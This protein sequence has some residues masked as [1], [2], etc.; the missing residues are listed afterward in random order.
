MTTEELLR[1]S[2]TLRSL[3]QTSESRGMRFYLN[4]PAEV[5]PEFL[6]DFRP[7]AIARGPEG[8]MII[9]LTYPGR[10]DAKAPLDEIS[11]LVA[12]QK[13]WEF[14]AIYINPL[15]DPYPTIA[16]PTRR[17]LEG[18]FAEIE[19]LLKAGHPSQAFV[20][21]WGALESLA[22]LTSS[23]SED[24]PRKGFSPAQAIQM[25]AQDGY[26][27]DEP[28]KRLRRMLTLRDAVVH[29]D[30]SVDV[31]KDEVEWLLATLRAITAEFETFAVL[32]PIV[33][34]KRPRRR[35]SSG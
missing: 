2:P 6:G 24:K 12:A 25:L 32:E 11:K 17:Q 22:R 35:G 15:P 30:L 7:D 19:T 31:P 4:P 3:R 26:V 20:T 21:G 9:E 5:V 34:A 18:A 16:K 23:N 10:S 14:H 13:G 27:D 8:G 29:G 33:S 1:E 28:A